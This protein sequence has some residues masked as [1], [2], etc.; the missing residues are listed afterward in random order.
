MSTIEFECQFHSCSGAVDARQFKISIH[1]LKVPQLKRPLSRSRIQNQIV[2]LTT[3]VSRGKI[4][5]MFPPLSMSC[6]LHHLSTAGKSLIYSNCM[7][8]FRR[9]GNHLVGVF[10]L[11]ASCL[12]LRIFKF[13]LHLVYLFYTIRLSF[14]IRWWHSAKGPPTVLT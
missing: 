2:R 9:E 5:K 6:P 8:P 11:L 7:K 13:R 10:Y 3:I 1:R 12:H 4:P 14:V